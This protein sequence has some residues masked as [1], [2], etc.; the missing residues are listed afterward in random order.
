[1]SDTIEANTP[2]AGELFTA[3]DWIG[4]YWADGT[5][6]SNLGAGVLYCE[7]RMPGCKAVR[8]TVLPSESAHWRFYRTRDDWLAAH[9]HRRRRDA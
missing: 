7:L 3:Y 4:D 5:V 9:P 6:I 2:P 8:R 1:M